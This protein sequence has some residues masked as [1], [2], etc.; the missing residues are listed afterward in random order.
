LLSVFL[1]STENENLLNQYREW[2][3]VDS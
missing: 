3:L 1:Q 2:K